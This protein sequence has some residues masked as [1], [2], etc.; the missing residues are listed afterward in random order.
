MRSEEARRLHKKRN[1]G[2]QRNLFIYLRMS[3]ILV[4]GS[5]LYPAAGMGEMR[6]KVQS[7]P[8]SMMVG[9]VERT[10]RIYMPTSLKKGSP[11]PLLLVF[12]GGGGDGEG[13]E[14]LTKFS[15][16]AE[17]EGFIVVYPDGRYKNWNDGRDAS[18]SRA[19][20]EKNDDLGF[21]MVLLDA[22]AME[23]PIDLRRMYSAGISNGAIFSHY[24]AAKHSTRLAGIAAVVGGMAD[25]FYKEFKPEKPVSVLII[26]GVD[27][28][29]T[30]YRGGG[31]AQNTRGRIIDTDQVARMWAEHN[32]CSSQ[33]KTGV[34]PDRDPDDGC[35]VRWSIWSGGRAG[36]EVTLYAIEGGGHTWPGGAQYLP[37]RIIGKVCR[38]FDATEVIWEFF[39]RHPK[40]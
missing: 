8:R 29:L 38:D 23:Y 21:I 36:T 10:Y 26:Q 6:D 16:L 22:L 13:V 3:L 35:T 12:H 27:D 15:T 11:C 17:R 32:G 37:Q 19:H 4:V 7:I 1:I 14:R 40:P 34:L 2:W 28:P 24:L 30:P 5:L 18:V 9:A 39:K 25:P 31:I 33:P 20:S